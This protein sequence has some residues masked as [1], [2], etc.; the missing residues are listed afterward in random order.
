MEGL[1]YAYLIEDN[2]I[3]GEGLRALLGKDQRIRIKS[4]FQKGM[5]GVESYKSH[6]VDL[7]LLDLHLPDI[8]GIRVMEVL[9]QLDPDVKV[10]G[11]SST[12]DLTTVA[13]LL[14]AGAK[15]F[16]NKSAALSELRTAI[17]VVLSGQRFLSP[18]LVDDLYATKASFGIQVPITKREQEV[19]RL[20][21]EE[22]SNSEIAQ[23][24]FIST[25]TVET[26]KRNLIQKLRVRNVIGLARY[27]WDHMAE[28]KG[29]TH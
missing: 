24:L 20:I 21:A 27:Y 11:I 18:Q 2:E 10:L 22:M 3:F 28:P 23:L 14:R 5:D 7:V 8:S 9:K 29:I 15:G 19:L 13:G 26:H 17:E 1:F 4:C 6:P 25:R 16:M 12:T